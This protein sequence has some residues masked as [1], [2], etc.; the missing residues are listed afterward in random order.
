ME[1]E[2]EEVEQESIKLSKKIF[3]WVRRGAVAVVVVVILFFAVG[4]LVPTVAATGKYL[5]GPR[6][7]LV[8]G[9]ALHIPLGWALKKN[10]NHYAYIQKLS[11]ILP[12]RS[13]GGDL[14]FVNGHGSQSS[15]AFLAKSENDFK[16]AHSG[17]GAVSM[18]LND[19]WTNCMRVPDDPEAG[20]VT[21][22]CW[23]DNRGVELTFIGSESNLAEAGSLVE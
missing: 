14:L 2:Q 12:S 5:I 17:T 15:A 1:E 19:R 8:D 4:I 9:V 6:E 3:L 13:R 21:V 20:W 23:D 10:K 11:Y 7:V 18:R 22:G 16:A